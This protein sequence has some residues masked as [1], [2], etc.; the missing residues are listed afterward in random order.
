[1]PCPG[2]DLRDSGEPRRDRALA[3]VVAT[4]CDDGAVGAARQDMRMPTCCIDDACKSLRNG[5]LSLNS[6]TPRAHRSI[7]GHCKSEVV[8]DS[9]RARELKVR[10]DRA[11]PLRVAT[12][13]T[14]TTRLSERDGVCVARS[15]L[16]NDP[17]IGGNRC[18][19][20]RIPSPGDRP[21]IC[22]DR[23]RVIEACGYLH[24]ALERSRR[25]ELALII[26][27]PT[28]NRGGLSERRTRDRSSRDRSADNEGLHGFLRGSVRIRTKRLPEKGRR[29][30]ERCS[31]E[32][33]SR[34]C[35]ARALARLGR[36]C[37]PLEP[38]PLLI[39]VL[40][41]LPAHGATSLCTSAIASSISRSET[42]SRARSQRVQSR[43]LA[44]ASRAAGR[45]LSGRR[46]SSR[47][48]SS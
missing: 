40:P 7:T 38:H 28:N 17:E 13:A 1:M 3:E 15:N 9:N 26:P 33:E 47:A 43:T 6:T 48:A 12:P 30:H 31:K 10:G 29:Q 22:A 16:P 5:R 34:E 19:T 45:A 27:P 39:A 41:P 44:W 36:P 37:R 20:R 35:R 23:D 24:R 14:D 32:Q 11:L 4:P 25:R 2:D 18:L 21:P 8:A 42:P 46:P